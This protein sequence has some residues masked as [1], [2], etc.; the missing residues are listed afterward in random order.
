MNRPPRA[1]HYHHC[2]A[3]TL[4]NLNSSAF[5]GAR[6]RLHLRSKS[7]KNLAAKFGEC[8]TLTFTVSFE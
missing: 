7:K 2:L 5:E 8:G 1:P 6:H 3:P 4:A